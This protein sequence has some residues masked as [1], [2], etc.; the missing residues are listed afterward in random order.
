MYA[1]AATGADVYGLFADAKGAAI[2][3]EYLASAPTRFG[4]TIR[5]VGSRDGKTILIGTSLGRIFGRDADTGF[6]LE[7]EIVARPAAA[8]SIHRFLL[9]SSRAFAVLNTA[10]HGYV[11]RLDGSWHALTG[12][13]P[14]EIVYGLESGP[15]DTL[16]ASTDSRVYGSADQG[17]SWRL[18]SGGLPRRPHCA[19]L[20]FARDAS[21]AAQLFLGTYGRSLWVAAL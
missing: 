2:H 17:T 11:L 4:E 19:D 9:T 5:A 7:H 3:W 8:G 1:V 16:F 13:L 21:G 15:G 20:R 12:G 14:T 6:M 18:A 10:T